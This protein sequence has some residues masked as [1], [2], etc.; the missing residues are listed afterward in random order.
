M[1][2]GLLYTGKRLVDQFLIEQTSAS[3]PLFML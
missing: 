2:G 1:L 3:E